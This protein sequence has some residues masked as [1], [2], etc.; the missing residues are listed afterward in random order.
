MAMENVELLKVLEDLSTP[1]RRHSADCLDSV[2]ASID[3]PYIASTASS[4]T[5]EQI[6]ASNDKGAGA[7]DALRWYQLYW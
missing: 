7:K 2:M 6:A 1:S 4:M 3:V 5:I